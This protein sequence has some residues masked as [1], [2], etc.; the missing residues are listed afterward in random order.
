MHDI[1][2]VALQVEMTCLLNVL[3]K[4]LKL[5]PLSLLNERIAHFPYGYDVTDP[6][7]PLSSITSVGRLGGT[8]M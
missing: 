3:V 2:E 6:P 4:D 8:Y 7:L 1:L 5:L